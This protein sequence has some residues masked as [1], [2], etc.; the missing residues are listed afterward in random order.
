MYLRHLPCCAYIYIY[1]S[2]YLYMCVYVYTR[3]YIS[4]TSLYSPRR[5]SIVFP[6][7]Q[8]EFA[9]EYGKFG[10]PLKHRRKV[11]MFYDGRRGAYLRATLGRILAPQKI[12]TR[13]PL[14]NASTVF[15]II[16]PAAFP[17][18]SVRI[19]ALIFSFVGNTAELAKY[20]CD[21][22]ND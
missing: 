17:S 19:F 20:E 3:V 22:I 12:L 8:S 9:R 7:G 1:T 4:A 6:A 2:R 11:E 15:P 13:V 18:T 5:D 21:V 14:K 10:F 16:T